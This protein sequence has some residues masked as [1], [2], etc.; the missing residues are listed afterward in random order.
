MLEHL[1]TP[2]PT[3]WPD[4]ITFSTLAKFQL[5]WRRLCGVVLFP[6]CLVKHGLTDAPL[7]IEHRF[8]VT[9][10]APS[11]RQ[12][13]SR[14]RP[15]LPSSALPRVPLFLRPLCL[16]SFFLPCLAFPL[17]PFL[18]P[19]RSSIFPPSRRFGSSCK[20]ISWYALSI[21]FKYSHS[22]RTQCVNHSL[23]IA[24]VNNHRETI[25]TRFNCETVVTTWKP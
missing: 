6:C 16:A 10:A 11:T 18:L 8:Q 2:R 19:R 15:S 17:R 7:L 4:L 21:L 3:R 23:E 14:G 25:F 20:A 9:R 24:H 5:V 1:Q 12:L 13:R 22:S